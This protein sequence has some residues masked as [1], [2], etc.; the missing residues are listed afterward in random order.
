MALKVVR[1]CPL[2]LA[3]PPPACLDRVSWQGLAELHAL[4]DAEVEQLMGCRV[5]RVD[6]T[7]QAEQVAA[8]L[9]EAHAAGDAGRLAGLLCTM[10]RAEIAEGVVTRPFEET[11]LR[12]ALGCEER[13]SAAMASCVRLARLLACKLDAVNR[14]A[15]IT[16]DACPLECAS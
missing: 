10:A 5:A 6:E 8:Q 15:H 7:W 11:T 9:R 2:P 16:D 12:V 4:A 1:E 13:S 14:L 3:R